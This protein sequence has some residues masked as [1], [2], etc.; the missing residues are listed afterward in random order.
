[1]EYLALFLLLSA[2]EGLAAEEGLYFLTDAAPTETNHN[3]TSSQVAFWQ[4]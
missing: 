3:S 1:M 2:F 4:L